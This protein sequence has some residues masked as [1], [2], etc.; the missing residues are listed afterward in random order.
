MTCDAGW[1][2]IR[3]G[4]PQPRSPCPSRRLAGGRGVQRGGSGTAR[5]WPAC[6]VIPGP[7]GRGEW[8]AK[9][10]GPA[11]EPGSGA[12]P[13]IGASDPR[14]PDPGSTPMSTIRRAP[15]KAAIALVLLAVLFGL[16]R[17]AAHA[18]QAPGAHLPGGAGAMA[19][20][21][22]AGTGGGKATGTATPLAKTGT[23]RTVSATSAAQPAGGPC[24]VPGIGDIGGPARLL[25]ARP[26]RH[27]RRDRTTSASQ[28]CRSPSRQRPASTR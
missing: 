8:S 7:P 28:G 19:A 12:R 17:G 13:L 16:L 24:S 5:R 26:V 14:P 6:R 25:L 2:R 22:T 27:H 15:R 10:A 3:P 11:A 20:T 1:T 4:Q 9:R 21:R 23:A 18:G